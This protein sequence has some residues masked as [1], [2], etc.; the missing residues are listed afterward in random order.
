MPKKTKNTPT[1]SSSATAP[2]TPVQ[3]PVREW[4]EAMDG[5]RRQGVLQALEG[6][7]INRDD[8]IALFSKYDQ[9]FSKIVKY[10]GELKQLRD[11]GVSIEQV[12]ELFREAPVFLSEV[13]EKIVRDSANQQRWRSQ[14][15]GFWVLHSWGATKGQIEQ[16]YQQDAR[17]LYSLLKALVS[18][19]E[20]GELRGFQDIGISPLDIF[21]VLMENSR[22]S[23]E[24]LLDGLIAFRALGVYN[25]TITGVFQTDITLFV[26]I[27]SP[28]GLETIILLQN[29]GVRK[30]SILKVL[31]TNPYAFVNVLRYVNQDGVLVL[32]QLGIHNDNI[33]NL[34]KA[35]PA[36][37]SD[38]LASIS[39][40]CPQVFQE[41]GVTG[42]E[43]QTLFT[44]K[45]DI[46]AQIMSNAGQYVM[47]ILR[48]GYLS[49]EGVRNLVVN[50]PYLLYQIIVENRLKG[51]GALIDTGFPMEGIQKLFMHTPHLLCQMISKDGLRGLRSLQIMVFRMPE[52][53]E[54]FMHTPHLLCQMITGDGLE[55][56]RVLKELGIINAQL[57]NGC[58]TEPTGWSKILYAAGIGAIED[59]Q[60]LNVPNEYIISLSKTQPVLLG[61]MMHGAMLLADIGVAPQFIIECYKDDFET[62]EKI[63]GGGCFSLSI[64]VAKG[65]TIAG[66]KENIL[67]LD[68]VCTQFLTILGRYPDTYADFLVELQ[69]GP[70]A[71]ADFLVQLQ[72]HDA[73]YADFLRQ[74]QENP[75][76]YIN[77]LTRLEKYPATCMHFI[78]QIQIR[79]TELAYE[80]HSSVLGVSGN[81][82]GPVWT[83]FYV[84][85]RSVQQPLIHTAQ[86]V[87][88]SLASYL[89]LQDASRLAQA[90]RDALGASGNLRAILGRDAPS[91]LLSRAMP[92]VSVLTPDESPQPSLQASSSNGAMGGIASS[93]QSLHTEKVQK[94]RKHDHCVIS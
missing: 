68:G 18:K 8:I 92:A 63:L 10:A 66:I 16:W 30:G 23:Y 62:L 34:F 11:A 38:M 56:L 70:V 87:M 57:V 1:A 22:L 37:L 51:L 81:V 43:V 21:H 27:G 29:L 72:E 3:N 24:K 76:A 78:Q 13:L 28:M 35:N 55:G 80:Y 39:L 53:H 84:Q 36:L 74:L 93:S 79:P 41:M 86:S 44:E 17:H 31:E 25:K 19:V 4:P 20:Q 88:E 83:S 91:A 7:G 46:L 71:C 26:S 61:K 45:P 15:E 40:E 47:C 50:E 49:K 60:R 94:Q 82:P 69:K 90:T 52:I 42:E 48:E 65:W 2:V 73:K 77:L 59:L 14:L 89:T 33:V 12:G 54:L 5:Y 32:Q 58:I 6:A 67:S 9:L 85:S 75:A 64:L